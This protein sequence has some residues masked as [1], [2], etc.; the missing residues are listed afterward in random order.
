LTLARLYGFRAYHVYNSLAGHVNPDGKGFPDWV[1]LKPGR[2]VII[3]NKRQGKAPRP[4][5]QAW[6]DLFRAIPGA[7]VFT[8]RPSDLSSGRIERALAGGSAE[9]VEDGRQKAAERT[10]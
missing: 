3:E 2:L 8:F 10:A 9:A 6:L 7:E 5:Q 1:L 4:E